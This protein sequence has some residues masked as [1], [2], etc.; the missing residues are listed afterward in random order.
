MIFLVSDGMNLGAMSLAQNSRMVFDNKTTHWTQLYREKPVVRSLVETHS[1]NCLVTDSGAAA[2]AWGGG[3]RVNNGSI[4][5]APESG[6]PNEPLQSLL[7]KRNISTGLVSTA[8][9]THATPAG[10]AANVASRGDQDEIAKQ[11]RQRGVEVLLGGGQQYFPEELLKEFSDDGYDLLTNRNELLAAEGDAKRPLLGLFAPGYLPLAIDHEAESKLQKSDPTLAEMSELAVKRL[12]ALAKNQWFLMIEGA[13][14]DHCGHANDAAG[15]IREQLAFDDAVGSMLAYA[16]TRDDVLII[17]TT[18]H[19]CGGIQLNG[20][21]ADPKQGMA[22]GIYNGTD[23]AFRKIAGFKNSFEWMSNIS[24]GLSGPPLRDYL[25]ERTGLDLSKAE[26]KEAQGL[27]SGNLAKIF[28]KHHGIDWTGGNHTGELVEFCAYGPG[29][30][31]FPG[32]MK[33]EE[34]HNHLLR[35]L[36]IA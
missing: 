11:Y 21:N 33:N 25:V 13:R 29:S 2:S 32:F 34:I 6:K 28:S 20:V 14:I 35:A 30:H 12:D 8:T 24:S 5:I 36:D 18:D 16:A 10:F 7:K 22:P 26:I 23:A 9:I 3:R 27:K 1:S 31:L 17:V 19:G 4:N 15:S